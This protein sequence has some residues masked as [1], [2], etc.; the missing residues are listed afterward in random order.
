MAH[1]LVYPGPKWTNS[2]HTD[3][4]PPP[5][6]MAL[7]LSGSLHWHPIAYSSR[8]LRVTLNQWRMGVGGIVFQLSHPLGGN[9]EVPRGSPMDCDPGVH[10]VRY[11]PMHLLLTLLP[12][13]SHFPTSSLVFS[14]IIFPI[15]SLHPS[16]WKRV[17]FGEKPCQCTPFCLRTWPSDETRWRSE[18]NSQSGDSLSPSWTPLQ[19]GCIAIGESLR[20]YDTDEHS[21]LWQQPQGYIQPQKWLWLWFQL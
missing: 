16:L 4:V 14:R 1:L 17:C 6:P 3:N 18:A 9:S 11:V 5:T 19:F 7:P 13:L 20:G 2:V 10:R 15:H 8:D 12:C 21:L